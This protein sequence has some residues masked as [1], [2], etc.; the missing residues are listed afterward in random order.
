MPASMR[1]LLLFAGVSLALLH[2]GEPAHE[3]VNSRYIVEKV[4]CLGF[5]LSRA[6]LALRQEIDRLVGQR[7][8]PV[9]VSGL[10]ARLGTELRAA[11]SHRVEKGE[12]PDHVRVI[13]EGRPRRWDEKDT[14]VT[15]LAYHM[16]QGWSGG[17]EADF[18]FGPNQIRVGVLSDADT[19]VER[20][21]GVTAGYSVNL[22]DRVRVHFDLG[23]FH[24]Q[25]ANST[26]VALESRPDVPGIY[27]ERYSM[28][29]EVEV[30]LA[31]GLTWAAG[32]DFQL[33]QTQFPAAR[34]EAANAVATTLRHRRR[35]QLSQSSAGQE[36]DAGYNLRAATRSLDSD[37]VYARHLADAAY[38]VRAGHHT[39]TV[40]A[41]A[42]AASGELPL[43]ER[44]ALGDTHTLRG[45]NKFDIAPLGG[46]RV[47]HASAQYLYRNIG[48]FY[49]TGSVWDRQ[50]PAVVR[51]AA[52]FTVATRALRSGPYL[53]V[54][55]PIRG[56]DFYPLFMM[57]IDF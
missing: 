45:W 47:A 23:A 2:A 26:L 42:G 54:G 14:E 32:F 21:A 38:S 25:W 6:S 49:D 37:Y 35:W 28:S 19:L 8:D 17:V 50:Q 9:A 29:P 33:F 57:G 44:F 11:V 16:K 27:R 53:T 7:L 3:N 34:F 24:Q 31:P 36:V 13:F 4:E 22:G 40:R 30:L 20:Y 12:Q 5:K 48:V 55:F 1:F 52:G 18:H 43:Y 56:D 46:T 41:A 51:H 39:W 15:K 10:A